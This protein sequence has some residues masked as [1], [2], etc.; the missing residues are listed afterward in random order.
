MRYS[1]GAWFAGELDFYQESE[2]EPLNDL[3][4][5]LIVEER[6]KAPG[7]TLSQSLEPCLKILIKALQKDLCSEPAENFWISVGETREVYTIWDGY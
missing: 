7:L 1:L 5:S 6:L 4:E 2:I 3:Y